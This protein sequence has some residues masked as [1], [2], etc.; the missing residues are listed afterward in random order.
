MRKIPNKYGFPRMH[1]EKNEKRDFTPDFFGRLKKLP[2]KFFLEKDY[3]KKMGFTH[4]DYLKENPH[5]KFVSHKEAYKQEIIVVLRAPSDDEL[6]LMKPGSILVSMLHYPTRPTRNSLIKKLKLKPISLDSIVDDFSQ[7]MVVNYKATSWNGV[8]VG[9][10]AF[11]K[12]FK[13]ER[14]QRFLNALIL[15]AGPVGREACAAACYFGNRNN[16]KLFKGIQ[17]VIPRLVNSD[18]T[19]QMD[20]IK[21]ILS[22]TH[23]LIDATT[24]RDP[25]KYVITNDELNLMPESS[26]II[27]LTADPY[28]TKHIP[29]YVKAIE[30]IPTG[31]L[32]KM[33][34]YPDDPEFDKNIPNFVNS[35]YKRT[36]VSC[37]AWPGVYPKE[38]M[39]KYGFQLEPFINALCEKTYEELSLDNPNPYV[40]ALYRGTY[41]FYIT[42]KNEKKIDDLPPERTKI[43]NKDF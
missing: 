39:I 13:K 15:G 38:C 10:K 43:V 36:V 8:D 3:G 33:I 35:N 26:I 9:F 1:K 30:G 34:F 16:K 4:E 18:I 6:K 12:I 29:P 17:G 21:E 11:S 42:S 41:K 19:R 25:S 27:D 22:E 20:K 40:R 7:R 14:K 2:I 5:I 28:D 32:D 24:R 37:N 23:V 31:T